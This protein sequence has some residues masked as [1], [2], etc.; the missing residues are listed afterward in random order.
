MGILFCFGARNGTRTR[1]SETHA[2]QTCLS[3]NSSTRAQ[4]VILYHTEPVMSI[5]YSEV[6]EKDFDL[7][8]HDIPKIDVIFSENIL[9]IIKQHL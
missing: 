5:I 3:A 2:P 8:E 9:D 4:Q 1:T 6:L 7:Q